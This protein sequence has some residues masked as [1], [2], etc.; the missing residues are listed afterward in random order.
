MNE[1]KK[2]YDLLLALCV[3]SRKNGIFKIFRELFSNTALKG[4]KGSYEIE[5]HKW[6][7]LA[8]EMG[9]LPKDLTMC[10]FCVSLPHTLDSLVA[11]VCRVLSPLATTTHNS[12]ANERNSPWGLRKTS[13]TA[14]FTGNIF[15]WPATLRCAENWLALTRTQPPRRPIKTDRSVVTIRI[16][17]AISTRG[18]KCLSTCA[19]TK[20]DTIKPFNPL[21]ENVAPR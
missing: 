18:E 21:T 1:R 11:S 3:S 14:Q 9:F 16:C 12:R 15:Y 17:E 7:G 20:G 5:V 10:A 8:I 4:A 6:V 19:F 2:F 13:Q